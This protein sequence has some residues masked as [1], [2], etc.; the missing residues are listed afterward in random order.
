MMAEQAFFCNFF[1]LACQKKLIIPPHTPPYLSVSPEW[2]YKEMDVLQLYVFF[3]WHLS[4]LGQNVVRDYHRSSN[5]HIAL[6]YNVDEKQS[7]LV[8]HQ[9]KLS[10]S[11]LRGRRRTLATRAMSDFSRRWEKT[12]SA[13]EQPQTSGHFQQKLWRKKTRKAI[14]LAI[15]S[16]TP[17]LASGWSWWPTLYTASPALWPSFRPCLWDGTQLFCPVSCCSLHCLL[18]IIPWPWLASGSFDDKLMHST[19]YTYS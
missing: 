4:Y 11:F 3:I 14:D 12:E 8:S 15:F 16:Q 7:Y 2:C 5:S 10:P 18:Q 19:M 17:K 9:S 1:H 6:K 13:A